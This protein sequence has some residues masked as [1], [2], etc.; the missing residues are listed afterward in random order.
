MEVI[1]PT[2]IGIFIAK[3][4]MQDQRDNDEELIKQL[5]WA[6][7]KRGAV[8]IRIAFYHQRAIVEYNKRVRPRFFRLRS[9]VLKRVLKNIVEVGVGKLQANWEVHYVVIKVGHLGVYHLQTLDDMP[10]FRPW[11]VTNLKQYYQ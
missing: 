5:D 9:L 6:D 8:A 4:A 3:T 7:E 10:L 2:E 11:N 1:I